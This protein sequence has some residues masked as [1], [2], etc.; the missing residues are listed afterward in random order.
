MNSELDNRRIINDHYQSTT[1]EDSRQKRGS[2]LFMLGSRSMCRH[3]SLE[4]F[5]IDGHQCRYICTQRRKGVCA[6]MLKGR[7][8]VSRVFSERKIWKHILASTH[9]L[10]AFLEESSDNDD[11]DDEE[12]E[13]PMLFRLSFTDQ[14]DSCGRAVVMDTLFAYSGKLGSFRA[15]TLLFYFAFSPDCG[16]N[17]IEYGLPG[18]AIIWSD[19]HLS[20]YRAIFDQ[21]C[22]PRSFLQF[23]GMAHSYVSGFGPCNNYC[24]TGLIRN[25]CHYI[26]RS[27]V[28][29]LT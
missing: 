9:I 11:D 3:D 26:F 25:E 17:G 28:F 12:E 1:W 19:V 13:Q 6:Y 5:W 4:L 29:L 2:L 16:R 24:D 21:F 22:L 27:F 8:T 15:H 18:S 23:R 20:T 10:L 14:L 7:E